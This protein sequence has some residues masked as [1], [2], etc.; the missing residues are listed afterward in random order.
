[1]ASGQTLAVFLPTDDQPPS[2]GYAMLGTRN[3]HA[4]INF[5]A[6]TDE[7]A[8]FT[9]VLGGYAGGGLTVRLLWCAVSATSGNVVWSAAVERIHEGTLDIDADSFAASKSVTATAPGTSG[10]TRH[11]DI[12]FAHGAEIDSLSNNE[13]FRLKISRDADHASDTMTGDAQILR[14]VILET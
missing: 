2:T 9:G 7:A 11:D 5:D 14:V 8:I 13:A 6:A 10:I 12:T 3:G 4:A 1:M